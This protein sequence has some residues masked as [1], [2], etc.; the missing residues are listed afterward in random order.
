MFDWNDEEL[1]NIIWDEGG[2][3]DD[4]IVPFPEASE[5]L[6]NKK[7]VN[8]EAATCK[9]TK[10]K[11]PET[12]TDCHENLGSSSNVNNSGGLLASGYGASSW[13]DSSLSSAAKIDQG[14]MGTELSKNRGELS[15]LSTSRETTQHEKDAQFFQNAEEGKEQGDFVDY[16]WANIGSFDDL[17]RIF[18]HDDPIFG[19]VS[20]ENSDELWSAKDVSNNQAHVPLDAPSPTDALRNKSEPFE[21]KEEHGHCNDQS[22]SPSYEKISGPAY[23][24][25]QNSHTTTDNVE[26]AGD[27]SKP[28]G[29]EQQSL[30]KKNQL[31]TRK[32]SQIKQEEKDLQ[33]F[34]G[35]WSSSATLARQFENQLTP[36]VLQSSPSSILGQPNKLQGPETLY[37][38]I[39]NPYAAPSVYGNL[40]NTYP[41]MPML[42]QI[43]SGNLRHQPVLS[44]YETS[45][46]SVNALKSYAGSIN[47]QTMTPQEKIE[48]LRRRQQ[49]QAMLAIQK[50]QQVLGHQVP[51]TSKSVAQKC[52]PEIQSHLS[53]G[54][55]P[56]IED[57]STYPP[58]EQV[59][60]NTISLAIDD[61]F[62]EETI[63]YRLQDVISKLDVT[64][65]LCIRDSLFRLAQSAT[66]RHY[67][68]DTSST[69]K[70]NN[71]E[72]EVF[73]RE[74]SSRQNRVPDIETE[75]N[76]IDRTVARLVFHRPVEL[77]GNYSDKLESP[78]STKVQ[79]ENKAANQVD[80]PMGCLQ[81]ED[82]RSHQQFSHLGSE[83]PCQSFE[84]QPMHQIKNSLGITSENASNPQEFEA[85][86]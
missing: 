1:A 40:T 68:S 57:L 11:Q 75:T 72:Y 25:I 7:E 41:A 33:D 61:D 74:E 86:Q 84:V 49:M 20:L 23:Q 4:H 58:I 26:C 69:N 54:T 76:S 27:R 37:Q 16:D 53:D 38:N 63:L 43:Q 80:F 6:R 78:V 13:P 59:D 56:K 12:N 47:P 62:V 79:C 15:K 10:R 34:Y 2:E 22:F 32:K 81:E 85:S 28:T 24:S 8:Q 46:S 71:E 52:H 14:S 73:A 5:D 48:K 30:R 9:L 44:G 82:L 66:Q 35:N 83:N 19:N 77:T 39:I 18:S 36:S 17:D 31:N 65:R 67:T 64:T 3:S 29:K 70:N 21:I 45:L 51:S 50:Q 55:D 60:S 42:S